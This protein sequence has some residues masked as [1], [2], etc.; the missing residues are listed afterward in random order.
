M[1]EGTAYVITHTDLDGVGAAAAAL[2]ILG[3]K[4]G[5]GAV[6]LYTE[7]YALHEALEGLRDYLEKRDV[8][9]VTDLGLNEENKREAISA[10]AS[11]SRRASVEVYDHHVWDPRDASS[12]VSAGVKVYIDRSTCATGVVVRHATRARGMEPEPFLMELE[13]AVCSADLWRWDHPLSPKLYRAVGT[14][15]EGRAW[16][17]RVL[18]KFVEG[19]LWDEELEGKLEEYYSLELRNM[20]R[21]LSSV[22]VARAGDISVAA[23]TR[24]EGPPANSIVGAIL[25]ARYKAKIAVIARPNGSIS[26]RSKSVD[27]QRIAASL[28]GG[29]HVRAA[30]ARLSLPPY[31]KLLSLLTPR[32]MSW[33]AARQVLS[34]AI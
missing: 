1:S 25:L 7:P 6:V 28:G 33:Y 8:V 19:K 27:V 5:E 4:R 3:R 12:L 18:D 15:E 9:F 26:L 13:S 14:R 29:G 2:R 10:F 31:I 11:V 21:I 30:G 17:D 20:Q 16:R 32:A 34:K 23:A 22:Y 24:E